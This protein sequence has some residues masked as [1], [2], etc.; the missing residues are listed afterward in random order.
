MEGVVPGERGAEI[1]LH[2]GMRERDAAAAVVGQDQVAPSEQGFAQELV[3]GRELRLAGA[4]ER[5][6]I[7]HVAVDGEHG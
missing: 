4:A 1:G 3:Q 2:V 7:A 5:H 6:D